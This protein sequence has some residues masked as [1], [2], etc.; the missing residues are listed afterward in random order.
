MLDVVGRYGIAIAALVIFAGELGVPTGIPAEILL[1]IA[2]AYG[3][4]SFPGLLFGVVIVSIGD[5]LG[6]MSL[7]MAVR[8]GG[9]RLLQ[10]VR[11]RAGVD[12]DPNDVFARIRRRLGGHDS[13]AVFVGRLLPLIRMPA[14]ICAGLMRMSPRTFFI[15]AAPA[16]SLWAGIPIVLGYAL[17]DRVQS[18][19]ENYTRVSHVLILVSPAVGVLVAGI[20]WIV[21][22]QGGW[23]RFRRGR[24]FL[25]FAVAVA[26]SIYLLNIA[27][28]HE[29]GTPVRVP[30][31]A[32]VLQIWL[33]TL[34]ILALA[35]AGVAF[36][37]L[38]L[39]RM[40]NREHKPGS[41]AL[42]SEAAVTAAWV[43]LLI[44]V[45]AIVIT[46]EMRYPA[47]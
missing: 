15:G 32:P 29:L 46:I 47:M 7:F 37:D 40:L 28:Q 10:F 11:E 34:G 27:W 2:G 5:I 4:H 23:A 35:L 39:A 20:A 19:A 42:I 24:S 14:T 12:P 21:R 8:S 9:V 1:L 25:G 6:T 17:Q 3:V 26:T 41:Q 36:V 16:G 33:F 30:L 44:A 45:G 18:F 31:P 22:G 13:L 43:G 38:R